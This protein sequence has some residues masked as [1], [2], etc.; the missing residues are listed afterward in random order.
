M[1]PPVPLVHIADAILVIIAAE[2]LFLTHR[3]TRGGAG[4]GAVSAQSDF[5]RLSGSGPAPGFG[6]GP[7]G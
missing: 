1:M 6:G 5:R 3:A 4:F 2:A 7:I